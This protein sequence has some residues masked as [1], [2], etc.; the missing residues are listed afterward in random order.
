MKTVSYTETVNAGYDMDD[1]LPPG[2]TDDLT[3][4]LVQDCAPVAATES[5]DVVLC[6]S[7]S[8]IFWKLLKL[9]TCMW[10]FSSVS[11]VSI[12]SRQ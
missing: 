9:S 2:L 11:K 6:F 3:D 5:H 1:N 4:D 10:E 7:I 8:F 12:I